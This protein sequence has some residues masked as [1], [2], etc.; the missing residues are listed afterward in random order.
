MLGGFRRDELVASIARP[1]DLSAAHQQM[2]EYN[3]QL[4][5][6]FVLRCG[7]VLSEFYVT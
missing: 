1:F 6:S 2:L 4:L 7:V 3:R 5:G